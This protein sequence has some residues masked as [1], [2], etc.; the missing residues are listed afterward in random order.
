MLANAVIVALHVNPEHER[1]GRY[2][3]ITWEVIWKSKSN[4]D[5]T[6]V[7]EKKCGILILLRRLT[8]WTAAT[9]VIRENGGKNYAPK[10]YL[11]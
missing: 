9:D 1:K 10:P 11:R 2:I 4:V 3:S 8:D 5:N 6:I 7:R